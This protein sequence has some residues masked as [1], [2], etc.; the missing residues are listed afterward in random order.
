MALGLL[1]DAGMRTL[2]NR[3]HEHSNLE[4]LAQWRSSG[5]KGTQGFDSVLTDALGAR[6]GRIAVELDVRSAHALMNALQS[7]LSTTQALRDLAALTEQTAA[8]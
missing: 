7:A 5:W 8:R 1:A 2:V 4:S 6:M 3:P